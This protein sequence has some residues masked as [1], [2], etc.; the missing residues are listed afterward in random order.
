MKYSKKVRGLCV[1]LITTL[2]VGL[3]MNTGILEA[4]AAVAHFDGNDYRMSGQVDEGFFDDDSTSVMGYTKTSP[5]VDEWPRI[6]IDVSH[7][8]NDRGTIDWSA[9][10]N[11]GVD[12]VIVK[13]GGR[14][15]DGSFYTDKCYKQNIEGALAAGLRVGVYF[16]S[17]AVT[18]AEAREEANYVTGLIYMYNITLPICMD[19]EWCP[20]QYRSDCRL[21]NSRQNAAQRTAVANAFM[22]QCALNGY[23]GALYA[24]KSTLR[25]FFDGDSLAANGRV[26]IAN[27]SN[28][29]WTGYLSNAGY[30]ATTDYEKTYDF[31][32]FSSQGSVPGITGYVD[33]DYWY[34]DGTI[35][36]QDY[37][38][39]FDATYYGEHNA[40]V[41]SAVGSDAGALLSHFKNYGMAEGRQGCATFDPKSYYLQYGDLRYAYG[42]NWPLYYQHYMLYG[43][44]EGRQGTG[45]T[46]L[47]NA[48]TVY[49][50]I[51]YASV[52]D[53]NY[54]VNNNV[55]VKKAYG[56]D[57]NAVLA[58]FVNY[59][60]KEGRQAKSTFNANSYRLQYVDLRNAYGSNLKNY[61]L[62]YMNYG[63][64]EGRKGAGC[65][66][67][68][69]AT[70]VYNG[71][72]YSAVYD[73]YYYVSNNSDI[74]NA[75]GND[76]QAVL[77]HFVN[78]GMKEGRQAKA[79]FNAGV[80]REN[81]A[82]LQSAYG[83]DLKSYYL[84][85]MNFGK[86]EGRSGI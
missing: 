8:Q 58:H 6:G 60:M 21:Y 35:S 69:G 43:K 56:D 79:D 73:Y 84:H 66:T 62:H 52:Y 36:G 25:N 85:Y 63:A 29:Q 15:N 24:N 86:K 39:V 20:S 54:Y 14:Y 34:D 49:N 40:D 55:D 26:W 19:Y 31:F 75:Y 38:A 23:T 59:G 67:V 76:D 32:Q 11:S 33:L 64:K 7:W 4:K 1:S 42:T 9:V 17:E 81:Y 71:V 80:Y 65:T 41:V 48:T 2:F 78:Y 16:W 27:Y 3:F 77:A 68:Q 28:P 46:A 5:R 22:N 53:Y 18:E 51:N 74:K 13:V 61:Y 70:T 47:Q 83:N 30:L 82:D 57:E 44:A 37:S 12:F 45:C 72:D 50:G 10:R